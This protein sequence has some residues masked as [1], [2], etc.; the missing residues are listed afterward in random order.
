M[1]LAAG[2]GVLLAA[3]CSHATGATATPVNASKAPSSVL[4]AT[5]SPGPKQPPAWPFVFNGYASVNGTPV[6]TGYQVVGAISDYRSD[7]AKVQGAGEFLGL[8]VPGTADAIKD[9]WSD[10]PISFF[11]VSP[12]GKQVESSQ[13]VTFVKRSKP[14]VYNDY[15]LSFPKLP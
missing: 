6:P 14:T 1:L 12:S 9:N 5:T 10:K 13:S 4:D 15:K 2:L 7:P 3:A 8:T 11:L